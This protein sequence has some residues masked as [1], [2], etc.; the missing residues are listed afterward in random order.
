MSGYAYLV[1]RCDADGCD[2]E[3]HTPHHVGTYT[4]VRQASRPD[5]WRTR[6]TGAGRLE[7]LCP[8]HATPTTEGTDRA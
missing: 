7:D 2:A 8:D 5:G 1:I 4:E 6:R 3:T